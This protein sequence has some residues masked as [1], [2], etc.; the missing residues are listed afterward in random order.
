MVRVDRPQEPEDFDGQC[1]IPGHKWLAEHPNLPASSRKLPPYWKEFRKDLK[2]GFSGLC[3][4]AAMWVGGP[5]T[6]D[7]FISTSTDVSLAYEW[8]NYRFSSSAL[9]SR[10]HALDDSILDPFEIGDGWFEVLIPS[11][12]MVLTDLVPIE[13]RDKAL[14]TLSRLGLRDNEAIVAWRQEWYRMYTSGLLTLA[15]L[16]EKAPLIAA[17]VEKQAALRLD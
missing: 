9:N 11:C 10:K 12:Q 7:H 13:L 5:G 15:G 16:R 4:Y 2:Q 3:G 14:F 17:A 1:R 6:V 8:D